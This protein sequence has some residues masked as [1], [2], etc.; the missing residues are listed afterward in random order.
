MRVDEFKKIIGSDI[1]D[2]NDFNELVKDGKAFAIAFLGIS[3]LQLFFAIVKLL[4]LLSVLLFM[5]RGFAIPVFMGE[6]PLS[7]V[8]IT[9]G[10]LPYLRPEHGF[11]AI[12]F[13]LAAYIFALASELFIKSIRIKKT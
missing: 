6:N 7:T 9:D 5:L 13:A 3:L 2:V 10:L 11:A 4:I 8:S 1:D 12:N